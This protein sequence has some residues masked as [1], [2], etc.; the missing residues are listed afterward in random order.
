MTPTKF[1]A[2]GLLAVLE[3][4]GYSPRVGGHRLTFDPRPTEV[5]LPAIRLLH[6][7]IRAIVTNRPWLGCSTATGWA[8]VIDSNK[9]VP[10]WVGLLAVQ[11]DTIWDRIRSAAKFDLPTCF[12]EQDE[13]RGRD[14]LSRLW[15]AVACQGR[16][17]P[18]RPCEDGKPC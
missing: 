11:G 10:S 14:R 15:I 4:S 7:G 9:P 2:S 6:T 17:G 13:P 8:Q 16:N 3:K 12:K 1:T 5:V 18:N